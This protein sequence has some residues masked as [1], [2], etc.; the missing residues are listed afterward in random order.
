MRDCP[1]TGG[2]EGMEGG[3]DLQYGAW[4]RESHTVRVSFPSYRGLEG[5]LWGSHQG[6]RGR[7]GTSIYD[8]QPQNS[9]V[10]KQR[11]DSGRVMAAPVTSVVDEGGPRTEAWLLNPQG[12]VESWR[13]NYDSGCKVAENL[14]ETTT[15]ENPRSAKQL[16]Q[17]RIH[18]I[19]SPN[20]EL[21]SI[22]TV[23]PTTIRT[24]PLDFPLA[25]PKIP[26]PTPS[27][28]L[29]GPSLVITQTTSSPEPEITLMAQTTPPNVN[30]PTPFV[31]QPQTNAI[32]V[33][34][35]NQTPKFTILCRTPPIPISHPAD[36]NISSP[37]SDSSW[38][39]T[40]SLG[41]LV[42]VPIAF[43]ASARGSRRGRGTGHKETECSHPKG[44][45]K[46]KEVFQVGNHQRRS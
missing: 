41:D 25:Q 6:Q 7:R 33:N 17:E 37:T 10:I 43:K 20:Q 21:S 15:C 9:K 38:N 30:N 22:K 35:I 45:S 44:Y 32:P 14:E 8:F 12:N 39:G 26:T 29:T 34:Q 11:P 13:G 3:E 46:R 2:G 4:L 31:S 16:G 19:P 28:N 42:T 23:G 24:Q 1:S 27:P 18:N 5:G 36:F 40:F